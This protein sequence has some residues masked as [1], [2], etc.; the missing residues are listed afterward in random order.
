MKTQKHH[1]ESMTLDLELLRR[2]RK[3][4][5]YS[6]KYVASVL[7]INPSGWSRKERG[8]SEIAVKEAIIVA[9]LYGM[10][11]DELFVLNKEK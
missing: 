5:G 10:P 4:K 2:A 1:L 9:N 8:M 11:I 6:N 7:G 3:E